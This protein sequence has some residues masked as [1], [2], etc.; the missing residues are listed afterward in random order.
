[1]A[2]LKVALEDLRDES[3][4]A[5][6][7]AIAARPRSRWA[8][9]ATVAVAVATGAAAYLASRSGAADPA[10]PMQAVPLTSL[11]GQV[12]FP[13]FSPD[14]EHIAFQWTGAGQNN[15]DIYVQQVGA[16]TPLRLTTDAAAGFE[17]CLGS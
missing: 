12:R 14:G 8:W 9:A 7:L 17:S 11:S 5:P 3:G 10:E 6:Q 13:A 4:S 1:M 16:G 15:Q 2:D